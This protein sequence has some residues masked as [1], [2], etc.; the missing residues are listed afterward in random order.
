MDRASKDVQYKGETDGRGDI[1]DYLGLP[2][3]L[4]IPAVVIDDSFHLIKSHLLP[5]PCE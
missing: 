3:F 2:G 5:L 4:S 1:G